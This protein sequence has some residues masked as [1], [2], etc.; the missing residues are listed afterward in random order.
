MGSVWCRKHRRVCCTLVIMLLYVHTRLYTHSSVFTSYLCTSPQH[1]GHQANAVSFM[2]N[3]TA[4]AVLALAMSDVD[5]TNQSYYGEQKL[6]FLATDGSDATLTLPKVW[7]WHTR[8]QYTPSLP[9]P[10]VSPVFIIY[11][12]SMC[13]CRHQHRTV[14]KQKANASLHCLCRT[15]PFLCRRVPFTMCSG[16]LMAS[17]LQ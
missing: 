10:P 14:D 13:H 6:H 1:Y 11:C 9:L 5:A 4:T 12:L 17:T 15:R 8:R 7:C 2:W 3:S 16:P